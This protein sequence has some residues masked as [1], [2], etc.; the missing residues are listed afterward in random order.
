[1]WALSL[2]IN[3]PDVL[4]KAQRELDIDV[5]KERQVHEYDMS[6]LFYLKATIKETLQLYPIGPL[7]V[8]HQSMEDCIV[9]GYHIPAGTRLLVNLTKIHHDPRV[10]SNPSE[11]QPE[12]FLT[13]HKDYDVRG[14]NFE[15]IP[16]S[17]GRRM[18]PGVSFVLQVL[19]LTLATLLH[20]FDIENPTS[21]TLD[22]SES[23]GT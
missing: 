7:S 9:A 23:I 18:C 13:I 20:G 3:H 22:K 6:N 4:K 5:G 21:E 15:F 8:P 1:M 14:Q 2:L 10:W 17:N 19:Q 11:F 12:R 16:F